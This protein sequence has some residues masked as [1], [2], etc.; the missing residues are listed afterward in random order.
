MSDV[1]LPQLL[2]PVIDVVESAGKLIKT[3][4]ARVGGPRGRGDKADVE[5]RSS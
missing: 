1:C 5:L 2:I 3:E 4:W